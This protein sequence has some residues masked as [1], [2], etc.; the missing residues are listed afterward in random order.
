M[1]KK[2]AVKTN[3]NENQLYDDDIEDEFLKCKIED[4]PIP[5]KELEEYEFE[6]T[7]VMKSGCNLQIAEYALLKCDI[8][9]LLSELKKKYTEIKKII[10]E[11]MKISLD[12][13]FIDVK[14]NNFR[15][16]IGEN[17]DDK[18]NKKENLYYEDEVNE[19]MEEYTEKIEKNEQL[20]QNDIISI[21]NYLLNKFE[22]YVEKSEKKDEFIIAKNNYKEKRDA[23]I[24][25]SLRLVKKIV[26]DED[27]YNK[28][29]DEYYKKQENK[30][31]S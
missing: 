4:L 18:E 10:R 9:S 17:K 14:E 24:E 3:A 8:T 6:V 11:K 22:D 16:N 19:I 7:E 31:N 2:T 26:N 13:F 27:E 1:S 25:S 21:K 12:N 29:N 28:F 5:K 15:K 20:T 23:I 30:I